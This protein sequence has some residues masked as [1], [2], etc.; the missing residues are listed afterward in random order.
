MIDLRSDSCSRPTGAMLDAAT[1]APL[2][3]D[4]FGDDPTVALL[5]HTCA[6]LF[7]HEAGLLLPSGT[8]ANLVALLAHCPRGARVIVGDLCDIHRAEDGGA[9]VCGG[10]LPSPVRTLDTGRLDEEALASA[11]DPDPGGPPRPPAALVCLENTHTLCGGAVLTPAYT[12]QVADLATRH[13][14]PL[15]LDGARVG[16]AAVALGVPV[17]ELT[18][19]AQ[20]AQLCLSK[21]LRAPVGAVLTGAGEFVGAARRVRRMLGGGMRQAGVLAAAG[22]VALR[23][24]DRLAED[25]TTARRLAAGLATLPAVTVAP[26]PTNIV[27]FQVAGPATPRELVRRLDEH[28]VRMLAAPGG[29]L[30]AV[31]HADVRPVDVDDVLAIAENVIT[32]TRSAAVPA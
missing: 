23:E 21:G 30:R 7:G 16:N 5:E 6:D 11:L 13:G 28:G 4:G 25:H 2:G 19:P 15:H 31:T 17:R 32:A 14:V 22:L 24:L 18:A 3:D 12:R 26:V 10:L 9:A 29:R 27:L 20:S 1:R 8:M